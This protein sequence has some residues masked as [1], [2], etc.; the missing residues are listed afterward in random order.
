MF[1]EMKGKSDKQSLCPHTLSKI[2]HVFHSVKCTQ[3]YII[4]YSTVAAR[5]LV[6]SES[7]GDLF[8]LRLSQFN[9]DIKLRKDRNGEC[10]KATTTRP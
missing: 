7:V 8:W 3:D 9:N 4:L 2:I 5:W 1:S 10:V 6:L